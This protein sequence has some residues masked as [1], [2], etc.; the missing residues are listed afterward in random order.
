[1]GQ[2][3]DVWTSLIDVRFTPESGHGSAQLQVKR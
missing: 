2:K 3:A 1:M